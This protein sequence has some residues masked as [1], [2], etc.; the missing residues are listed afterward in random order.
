AAPEGPMAFANSR[1]LVA[2]LVLGGV[3]TFVAL[4]RPGRRRP[5]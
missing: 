5:E 4:G 2:F 3:L 1:G